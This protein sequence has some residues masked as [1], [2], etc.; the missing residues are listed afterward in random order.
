MSSVSAAI[1]GLSNVVRGTE[2]MTPVVA[3]LDALLLAA[4]DYRL[5]SAAFAM[6]TDG[7]GERDTTATAKVREDQ[8]GFRAGLRKLAEQAAAIAALGADVGWD[9]LDGIGRTC[10][11]CHDDHRDQ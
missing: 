3:E 8:E 7:L 5:T 10:K 9:E 4:T 2:D 1:L 11:S 6:N